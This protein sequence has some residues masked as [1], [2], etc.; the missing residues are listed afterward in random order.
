MRIGSSVA[1]LFFGTAN[2]LTEE[3]LRIKISTEEV[4][5][6]EGT[7]AQ[8]QLFQKSHILEKNNFSEKQSFVLPPFFSRATFL[9]RL[10]FQKT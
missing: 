7:S 5:F 8:H 10:L 9:E 2:F 6:E 3:L 4:I 1:Q